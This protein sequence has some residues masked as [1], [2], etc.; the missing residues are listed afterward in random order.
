[1]TTRI[2]ADLARF[3]TRLGPD[4]IARRRRLVLLVALVALA[5]KLVMAATTFGTRDFWHWA[6]FVAAV[7]AHGPVG[8][9]AVH[10]DRSFYNHP[11]GIGYLLEL[12][13]FG[14][15]HGV[16]I[17]FS[18]RAL[19]S[20]ADV[21][22]ALLVFELVRAR[23]T[24]DQA[25][26]AGSA[27]AASP[28]LF[29]ISG[30]H[31]NTDPIFVFFVLL[32]LYLLAERELAALAGISI[33]L[34]LSIKIVP[35]VVLA[36]LALAAWRRGPAALA[37][38]AVGGAVTMAVIWLPA[39]I[40]QPA[41]LKRN[42]LEY[43]GSGPSQ[44]GLSQLGHW[45]GDP[46]WSSYLA[47]SGRFPI[48]LLCMLAPAGLYWANRLDEAQA[49]A[50]AL[51]GFLFLTPAFGAQYTAWAVAAAYLLSIRWATVYNLG[52]GLLLFWVYT[53]WNGGLPWDFAHTWGLAKPEVVGA[54][55]VWASL[56][57]IVG[58]TLIGAVRRP[59]R[60][61]ELPSRP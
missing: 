1:M 18:I 31:G 46:F 20:L 39:V 29:I 16:S 32:G 12:V 34:A 19:A 43:A 60:G 44:W 3:G 25:A 15:G 45:F 2:R 7:H 47:G 49:V 17:N 11:P 51:L 13:H 24:L 58:R 27:V 41:G 5:L 26:F 59:V 35:V 40:G 9:Y 48:V 50:L 56:G 22:S 52:G 8:V 6:D 4:Q 57:V 23:R 33:A 55:L 37:R 42:V 54:F 30:F 38:F 21:G 61:A 10:F 36:V 28:I 53:R 14:A